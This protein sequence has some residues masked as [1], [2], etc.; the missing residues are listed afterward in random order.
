MKAYMEPQVT[1]I[2][3]EQDV[4]TTSGCNRELPIM[5]QGDIEE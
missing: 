3:I 5:P 2:M 1:V 4:I